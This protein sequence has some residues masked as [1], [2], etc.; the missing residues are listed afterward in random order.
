MYLGRQRSG[1]AR[2]PRGRL[3][4]SHRPPAG[5]RSTGCSRM[6]R[7]H[8]SPTRFQTDTLPIEHFKAQDKQVVV[9]GHSYGA[10][11]TARYLWRKGPG[12][13]DRYLIMAGR[14]DM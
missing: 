11:L 8:P 10:F 12:A 7:H 3:A 5:R 14:L 1:G 2:R 4:P 9:V 6:P 13:A